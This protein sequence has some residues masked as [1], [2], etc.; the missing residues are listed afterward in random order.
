MIENAAAGATDRAG[1]P[2]PRDAALS[3]SGRAGGRDQRD[4]GQHHPAAVIAESPRRG[5]VRKPVRRGGGRGQ[6][7]RRASGQD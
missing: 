2:V 4:V 1:Q 5:D 6:A 3:G 7:G